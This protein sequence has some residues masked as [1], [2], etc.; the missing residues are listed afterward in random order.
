MHILLMETD[1]RASD[2]AAH[3]LR[4]AGHTVS[5][6]H[7]PG[8]PTFPCN[9]LCGDR[10]CP[11]DGPDPVDAVVTVRAHPYPRP[12]AFEDGVVCALRRR[13]PLVVT[14]TSA[15]SPFDKWTAVV[16]DELDVVEAC[17]TAVAQPIADLTS[18]ARDEVLRVL[19]LRGMPQDGADAVVRRRVGG[20]AVSISLPS[21]SQSCAREIAVRVVSTLTR[22]DP[23]ASPVDVAVVVA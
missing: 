1:R 16:A 12:T 17:K 4:D 15:L 2:H 21:S 6:C 23:A 19:A 10:G 14:G 13:V 3:R 5:R 9:G 18:A 7:E 20:V 22:L 8:L 11:L